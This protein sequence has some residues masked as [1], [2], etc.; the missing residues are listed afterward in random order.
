MAFFIWGQ[1]SHQCPCPWF[2]AFDNCQPVATFS[3]NLQEAWA[4]L[5]YRHLRGELHLCT[6]MHVTQS[7][8]SPL[9][10]SH[11]SHSVSP[12]LSLL[13]GKI[14]KIGGG[15]VFFFPF[16]PRCRRLCGEKGN[17]GP[18]DFFL[19]FSLFYR[20]AFILTLLIY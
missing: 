1:N 17:I 9:L 4:A 16:F 2:R 7:T 19:L 18:L 15:L 8:F 12:H 5:L 6:V 14:M 10:I 20:R 11:I 13:D 3:V